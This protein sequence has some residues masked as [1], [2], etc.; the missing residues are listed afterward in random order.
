MA[1]PEFKPVLLCSESVLLISLVCYLLKSHYFGICSNIS[2]T[3]WSSF[4]RIRVSMQNPFDESLSVNDKCNRFIVKESSFQ[5]IHIK[6]L[7]PAL[8]CLFTGSL[9]VEVMPDSSSIHHM[10]WSSYILILVSRKVMKLHE[11][12]ICHS[13]TYWQFLSWVLERN[14]NTLA[15]YTVAIRTN[16]DDMWKHTTKQ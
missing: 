7:I 13:V 15:Y 10:Q 4:L 16:C 3:A 5:I 8:M 9:V 6:C 12:W 14:K 2:T 11:N 1:E